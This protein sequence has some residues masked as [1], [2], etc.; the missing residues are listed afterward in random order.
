MCIEQFKTK[1][2][3]IVNNPTQKISSHFKKGNSIDYHYLKFLTP[4]CKEDASISERLYAYKHP[5]IKTKCNEGNF[6]LFNSF[7]NGY[8]SFCSTTKSCVCKS[9]AVSTFAKEYNESNQEFILTKQK[10]TFYYRH[11]EKCK[12]ININLEF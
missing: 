1:I 3:N 2:E 7:N 4:Q 8:R 9:N 10:Q 12:K 6:F 11:S 5:S